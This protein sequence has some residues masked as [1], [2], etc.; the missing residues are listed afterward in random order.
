VGVA[1]AEPFTHQQS[2]ETCDATQC[3]LKQRLGNVLRIIDSTNIRKT[4]KITGLL[5]P[6]VN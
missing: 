4:P 1:R 3:G 2:V 5:R 6:G